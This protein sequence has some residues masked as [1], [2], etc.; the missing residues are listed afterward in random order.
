[1]PTTP[2]ETVQTLSDQREKRGP[3][4]PVTAEQREEAE[5]NELDAVKERE[6]LLSK[7]FKKK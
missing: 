6:Q 3:L 2:G 4:N 7:D 1:M 5:Q